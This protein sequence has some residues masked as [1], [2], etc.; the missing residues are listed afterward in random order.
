MLPLKWCLLWWDSRSRDLKSWLDNIRVPSRFIIFPCHLVCWSN[1]ILKFVTVNIIKHNT[2][3]E[4][5]TPHY[6]TQHLWR[7]INTTSHCIKLSYYYCHHIWQN[8][9]YCHHIWQ[10]YYYCHHIWQ[11]YQTGKLFHLDWKMIIHRKNFAVACL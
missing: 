5:S 7:V 6:Q 2:C 3:E 11:N 9:Y 1:G 8:Y 10:N 4:L